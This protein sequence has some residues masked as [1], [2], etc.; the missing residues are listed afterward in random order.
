MLLV[1]LGAIASG[2]LLLVSRGLLRRVR[3]PEPKANAK[4]VSTG[5]DLPCFTV[6][7]STFTITVAEGVIEPV[8]TEEVKCAVEGTTLILSLLPEGILVKKGQLVCEL[9]DSSFRDQLAGSGTTATEEEEAVNLRRQIER[10]KLYAPAD[11][12]LLWGADRS[13][14]RY[15]PR[16]G[17]GT[18][19][20]KGRGIFQVYDPTGPMR[21]R[22]EVLEAVID[23]VR[24]GMPA[25]I[26]LEPFPKELFTGTV[27]EIDPLPNRNVYF[28]QDLKFYDTLV[29]IDRGPPG[30]RPGIRAKVEILVNDL[31]NVLSLPLEAV[32]P[33]HGKD[34]A[35][36]RRSDGG[37]DWRE[38]TLGART[39]SLAEIKRGLQNGECV[40]LKPAV[41]MSA[42][43]KARASGTTPT[44]VPR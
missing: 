28:N 2:T 14:P 31:D 42:Q 4:T 8:R 15:N 5:S 36:V 27:R 37:F 34:L 16:I 33:F 25:R 44:P 13:A 6:K 3:E 22:T 10:C 1:V 9:D 12:A 19:V 38:I 23:Q 35:A 20:W 43:K 39:E 30:P 24:T 32:L 41:L 21:V 11:G 29:S 17:P 18:T 40:C 7:P 26:R